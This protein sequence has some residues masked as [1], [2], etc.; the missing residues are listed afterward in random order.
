M[1]PH[2]QE[3]ELAEF[4]IW[5]VPEHGFKWVGPEHLDGSHEGR[6]EPGYA[7]QLDSVL[8]PTLKEQDKHPP[9]LSDA[10]PVGS[11]DGFWKVTRP[12]DE[13][14]GLHRDFA[15]LPFAQEAILRF[16]NEHGSLFGGNVMLAG[17]N[18]DATARGEKSAACLLYGGESFARW[19]HEI[20]EMRDALELWDMLRGRDG[21]PD[22]DGLSQVIVWHNSGVMYVAGGR[23]LQERY[24]ALFEAQLEQPTPGRAERM[25]QLLLEAGRVS[26]RYEWIAFPGHRDHYLKEWP[27]G[28][29]VGPAKRYLVTAVNKKLKGNASPVLRLTWDGRRRREAV[30]VTALMPHNLLAAMWLGLYLEITGKRTLKRCPLCSAWFDATKDPRQVYCRTRASGCRKKAHRIRAEVAAGRSLEEVAAREGLPIGAILVVVGRG[31][32]RAPSR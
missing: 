14:P 28:D 27:P 7:Y 15:A 1:P 19:Q 3:E 10:I 6:W 24:R 12:L 8:S 22:L 11:R 21:L 29:V 20:Q 5:P 26:L 32:E 23:K 2:V 17:P 31:K 18:P 13:S 4:F 30:M 25:R 16:A 9:W